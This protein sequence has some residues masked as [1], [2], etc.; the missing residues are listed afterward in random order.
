MIYEPAINLSSLCVT[1]SF[2]VFQNVGKTA[3]NCVIIQEINYNMVKDYKKKVWW[4]VLK[5]LVSH[6]LD[7][8]L[9]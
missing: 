9:G 7:Y 3:N 4:Y 1:S 5:K 2:A 6:R 8:H